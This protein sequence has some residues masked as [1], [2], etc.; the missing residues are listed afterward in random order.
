MKTPTLTA[1][2]QGIVMHACP[3]ARSGLLH[4]LT[5]LLPDFNFQASA[6][7]NDMSRLPGLTKADLVVSDIRDDEKNSAAGVGWLM[8][9][10]HIRDDKPLVIITE[11]VP[12]Y[13]L[14]DLSRQPLL[15]LLALQT[16]EAVLC[17]QLGQIMAGK[18]VISPLFCAPLTSPQL[19]GALPCLTEA[20]L[21]VLELLHAGYSV[22]QIACRLSRSVKTV[23]AHK[24]HLMDKL[25]VDNE[26]ALF[27]RIRKLNEKTYCL[28]NGQ[29]FVEHFCHS[30]Y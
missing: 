16:P 24:R 17:E 2:K 18:P 10:Q 9:L 22:T 21:K 14:F 26:I 6:S 11:E 7:F 1:K 25:Q 23:S 12:E 3:L 15:S 8:W 19:P 29:Q 4:F 13:L 28:D 20:E 5:T 30:A 27:A